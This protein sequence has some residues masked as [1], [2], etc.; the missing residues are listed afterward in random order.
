M[1]YED[2]R[3]V[4]IFGVAQDECCNDG[5]LTQKQVQ[6][7]VDLDNEV[8]DKELDDQFISRAERVFAR[9]RGSQG[10]ANNDDPIP[11]DFAG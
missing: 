11:G 3:P 5:K 2:D 4:A 6:R 10:G 9:F 8:R 7:F 1:P